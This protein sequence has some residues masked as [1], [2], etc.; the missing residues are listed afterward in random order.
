MTRLTVRTGLA[1]AAAL[2]LAA[3]APAAPDP[4]R[5]YLARVADDLA[6]FLDG[7]KDDTEKKPKV[8]V[9]FAGP[10]QFKSAAAGVCTQV[11]TDLLRERQVDV[12]TGTTF[13]FNGTFTPG[14]GVNAVGDKRLGIVLKGEIVDVFGKPAAAVD[15]GGFIDDERKFAELFGSPVDLERQRDDPARDRAK[16]D[17]LVRPAFFRSGDLTKASPESRFG[18]AVEVGGRARPV[19]VARGGQFEDAPD[20]ARS[21][22]LPFVHL[23]LNEEYAIRLTNGSAFE[24]AVAIAVDGLSVFHFSEDRT[25]DPTRRGE[26]KWRHWIIPAGQTFVLPGWHKRDSRTVNGRLQEGKL[27][28][29]TIAPFEESEAAKLGKVDQIG[30]ITA[31]FH[32]CWEEGRTQ[33]PPDE[34]ATKARITVMDTPRS[35]GNGQVYVS[36]TT[37]T[38]V[39]TRMG[40]EESFNAQ[41]VK[42]VIGRPRASITLRYERPAP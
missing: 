30:T 36:A 32:A 19:K 6:K 38:E 33:P 31:T 40:Q 22:G 17:S 25:D 1:L 41:G 23:D 8:A 9:A 5:E 11:L 18:L 21:D 34:V 4:L 26:P 13:A 28:R 7:K 35:A 37:R 15:F 29:F 3:P 20:G 27:A 14:E 24:V 2:A 10:P 12:A 39:G 42:R 16:K